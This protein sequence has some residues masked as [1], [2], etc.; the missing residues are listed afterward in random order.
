[1]ISSFFTGVSEWPDC[2]V[3]EGGLSCDLSMSAALWIAGAWRPVAMTS[4]SPHQFQSHPDQMKPNGCGPAGPELWEFSGERK[5]GGAGSVLSQGSGSVG[6][7]GVVCSHGHRGGV[8]GKCKLSSPCKSRGHLTAST[9]S[10]SMFPR[11][12]QTPCHLLPISG[13][14]TS[15]GTLK[16]M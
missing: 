10:D 12:A 11:T 1:M 2:M 4:L 16:K 8:G 15:N 5:A 3:P 14:P 9:L 13:C 6:H 7:S